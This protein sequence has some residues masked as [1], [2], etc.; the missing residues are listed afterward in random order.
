MASI[1]TFAACTEAPCCYLRLRSGWARR[2]AP[3]VATVG[4]IE[5][6]RK[7][8]FTCE[9]RVSEPCGVKRSPEPTALPIP[10]RPEPPPC[11][12]DAGCRDRVLFSSLCKGRSAVPQKHKKPCAP[13][14]VD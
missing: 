14:P 10:P 11:S 1:Q 9:F 4:K 5:S 6:F 12:S 7:H 2:G 3:T 8:S 13:L